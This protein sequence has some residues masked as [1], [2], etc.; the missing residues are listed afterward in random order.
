MRQKDNY[1]SF[2]WHPNTVALRRC[3]SINIIWEQNISN[4]SICVWVC[5]YLYFSPLLFASFLFTAICRASSDNHFAFLH[6]FFLGIILIPTSSTVSPTSIHSSQALCLPDIVLWIYLSLSVTK[7]DLIYV[8]PEWS[9]G[10]PY[11]LQFKSEFGN[12]EF[13]IW[14]RVSFWSCLCWL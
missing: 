1:S 10:F 3:F 4:I 2:Q 7:R 5:V 13:M 9:S 8:I 6:F 14:A 12:K 11:F